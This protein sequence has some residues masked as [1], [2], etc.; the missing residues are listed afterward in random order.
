MVPAARPVPISRGRP[1]VYDEFMAA[2]DYLI[3]V[4]CETPTYVFEWGEGKVLEALCPVC[5]N[6]DPASFLSEDEF[7]EMTMGRGAE[8]EEEDEE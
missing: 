6:E 7:E 3:C 2:P 4:E 5:G 1:V 8:E